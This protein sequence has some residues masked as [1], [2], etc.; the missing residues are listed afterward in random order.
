L[1]ENS[2]DPW[3]RADKEELRRLNNERQAERNREYQ[4][5]QRKIDREQRRGKSRY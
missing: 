4:Q 1:A 3:E 2:D 5:R